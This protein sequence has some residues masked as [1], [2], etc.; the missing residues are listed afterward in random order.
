[1]IFNTSYQVYEEDIQF[2]TSTTKEQKDKKL[3]FQKKKRK[4]KKKE[5]ADLYSP[6]PRK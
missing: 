6:I 3:V 2:K 4:K 1:M 5:N